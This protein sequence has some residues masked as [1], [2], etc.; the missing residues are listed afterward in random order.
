MINDRLFGSDIPAQVKD[1]LNSRQALAGGVHKSGDGSYHGIDGRQGIRTGTGVI[2]QDVLASINSNFDYEA[3]L[4][5]RT[6]WARMWTG[7]RLISKSQDDLEDEN[8][9]PSTIAR[10]I[11]SVGTHNL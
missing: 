1:K 7:I 8:V 2:D 10:K 11:Y 5:S 4:S 9:K 3:D 6:P